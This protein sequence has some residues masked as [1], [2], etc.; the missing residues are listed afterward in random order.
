MADLQE[1]EQRPAKWNRFCSGHQHTANQYILACFRFVLVAKTWLISTYLAC[2]RPALCTARKHKVDQFLWNDMKVYIG[3]FYFS[4]QFLYW[5]VL[6][7][8]CLRSDINISKTFTGFSLLRL[9]SS[10]LIVIKTIMY[11]VMFIERK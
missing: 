9:G 1:H 8:C 3:L 10:R 5:L 4:D 2:F 7:Y 11:L 6:F